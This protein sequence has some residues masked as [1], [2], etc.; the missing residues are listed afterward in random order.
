MSCLLS[1]DHMKAR[2][3]PF[4]G[5]VILNVCR[6]V[7][8]TDTHPF[9]VPLCSIVLWWFEKKKGK[10]KVSGVQAK[11]ATS[12]CVSWALLDWYFQSMQLFQLFSHELKGIIKAL[13]LFLGF[14][15]FAALG[16]NVI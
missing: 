1:W 2:N 9:V 5:R 4:L 11:L 16:E 10:E 6:C 15:D 14:I 13:H 7:V 8:E 3:G 12:E